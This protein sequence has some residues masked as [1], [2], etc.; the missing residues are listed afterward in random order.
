V[1]HRRVR[2]TVVSNSECVVAF[3]PRSV[4]AGVGGTAP[5]GVR[6]AFGQAFGG[7]VAGAGVGLVE[8]AG[9]RLKNSPRTRT[10]MSL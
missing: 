9:Q 5:G 6:S 10:A 4:R 8:L 1:C 3:V 7:F 2:E